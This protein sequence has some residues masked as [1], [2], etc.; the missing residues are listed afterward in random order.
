MNGPPGLHTQVDRSGT[1]VASIR[2][3]KRNEVQIFGFKGVE[4]SLIISR[5]LSALEWIKNY[6]LPI[7][8]AL[9][10]AVWFNDTE[11]GVAKSK[12]RRLSRLESQSRPVV[13]QL[14]VLADNGDILVFSPLKD[15]VS[16]TIPTGETVVA[17]SASGKHDFLWA[18]TE[19]GDLLEVSVVEENVVKRVE[20][21]EISALSSASIK[22]NAVALVGSTSLRVVDPS[23][24][25]KAVLHEFE[26][27]LAKIRYIKR[28]S[29]LPNLVF[30]SRNSS[31]V[32]T[33][34]D[35][36]DKTVFGTFLAHDE[37]NYLELLVDSEG[38]ERLFAF[39]N[40]GIEVFSIE[41]HS[42]EEHL[43]VTTLNVE[44]NTVIFS[45]ATY[46]PEGLMGLWHH[47]NQTIGSSIEFDPE[48]GQ[49]LVLMRSN[50]EKK[51]KPQK[52]P[53]IVVDPLSQ[54]EIHNLEPAE[55]YRQLEE[56]LRD[57]TDPDVLILCKQNDDE[58]NIKAAVKQFES[59]SHELTI[60]L[61]GIV[62]SAVTLDPS[63]KSSLAVWLKWL[64][65]A[66]GGS[67]S[68][69]TSQKRH[70][71]ELQTSLNSGMQL[72]PKLLAL[73]GRLQLLKLQAELRQLLESVRIDD[74]DET[75]V[76]D[77]FGQT[78][79]SIVYA[80]GEND[81]FEEER[82]E[83]DVEVADEEDS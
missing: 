54:V 66:H 8:H 39:T 78:E 38:K 79:E 23:K 71:V 70:L 82:E 32:V 19:K 46:R 7:E 60:R 18:A 47:K 44:N 45:N 67:I 74:A 48:I 35:I 73:Q 4:S 37:V 24:S 72:M 28:S 3:T 68:A 51:K 2:S 31:K 27:E 50:K 63:R 58:T 57:K 81:D 21:G 55:L 80:N 1:Y 61:F 40:S 15:T 29:A 62:S 76:N 42:Q 43:P 52:E 30:I 14:A 75:V 6:E 83:S 5:K 65:L 17:I 13:S 22:G 36:V 64:L 16:R 25:K 49:N 33:C 69:T 56:L 20:L 59:S 9:L 41:D 26:E 11:E 77:S 34:Y 12:K 53:E 10:G